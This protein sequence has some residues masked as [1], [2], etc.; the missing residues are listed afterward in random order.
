MTPIRTTPIF[1]RKWTSEEIRRQKISKSMKAYRELNP[2]SEDSKRRM[3]V[4]QTGRKMSEA[5]K[6]KMSLA[7]LGKK[8]APFTEEARKNMS[9]AQKGKKASDET[10]A[11]LSKARKGKKLSP[12]T[13]KKM[14]ITRQ[15]K[16]EEERKMKEVQRQLVERKE[17]NYPEWEL[18]LGQHY[19]GILSYEKSPPLDQSY[20][21]E[22]PI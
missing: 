22:T 6:Q 10:R 11:K 21:L 13:R 20:N 18:F 5:A 9:L 19:M 3:S 1:V 7:K 4:S 15:R 16:V 12:E 8:R 17:E 14:S 2:V